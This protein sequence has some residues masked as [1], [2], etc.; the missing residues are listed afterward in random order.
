MARY[1]ED[2][3][4]GNTNVLYPNKKLDEYDTGVYRAN[5]KLMH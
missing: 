3:D 4:L 2:V 1:H 5:T